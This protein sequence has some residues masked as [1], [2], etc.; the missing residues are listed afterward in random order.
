MIISM[1]ISMTT[2]IT[3][4]STKNTGVHMKRILTFTLLVALIL[5][6]FSGCVVV[7]MSGTTVRGEGSPESFEIPVSRF[8]RVNIG[9][10]FELHYREA[11]VHR[12]SLEIQP[13]L[14]EYIQ[15]DVIDGEL[16]VR[17][18]RGVRYVSILTPV[19]TV[20]S[21]ELKGLE[22]SGASSFTTY[23]VLK[24]DTFSINLS[25]AGSSRLELDINTLNLNVSGAG[26]FI[27]FGK[28]DTINISMSGAGELEALSLESREGTVNFSG[29]GTIKVNSTESL[30]IRA[31]GI[32]TVLYKG[33]PSLTL[34]NS[35]MVT[36]RRVE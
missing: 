30:S 36:I 9:G 6:V 4:F 24:A 2:D 15:T 32:G 7:N 3:I 16:R 13:N 11:D 34:N 29:A 25:G 10:A 14:M 1:L 18:A 5:T 35:G 8:D 22:I 19:L 26:S 17:T 31:S 27:L 20:Y 12:V 33:S 21:P 28:A 23:D